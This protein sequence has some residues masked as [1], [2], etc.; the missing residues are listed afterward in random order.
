MDSDK[1]EDD[2]KL[3]LTFRMM[4]GVRVAIGRLANTPSSEDLQDEDFTQA[5]VAWASEAGCLP[6]PGTRGGVTSG[7]SIETLV[8]W[9]AAFCACFFRPG[10]QG[11]ADAVSDC[12]IEDCR[13]SRP[14]F[15]SRSCCSWCVAEVC[16]TAVH[17]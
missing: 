7:P 14:L 11:L 10:L 6:G 9:T 12:G 2:V 5:R 3:N 4:L 1:E 17:V 8:V 13:C 15:N 16:N